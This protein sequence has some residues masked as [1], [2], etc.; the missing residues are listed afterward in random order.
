MLKRNIVNVISILLILAFGVFSLEPAVFSKSALNICGNN[1]FQETTISAFHG[2][3][4]AIAENAKP[5]VL[6]KEIARS[7]RVRIIQKLTGGFLSFFFPC[8]QLS[9]VIL[10]ICC[11]K[12]FE[13][14]GI[15]AI[16]ISYIQKSDGKK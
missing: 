13:S 12:I 15:I 5:D 4:N 14:K 16:T 6:C 8:V 2:S 11:C 3:L 7:G 9:A 10:F 1:S